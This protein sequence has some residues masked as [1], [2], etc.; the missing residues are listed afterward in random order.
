MIAILSTIGIIVLAVVGV[1][2]GMVVVTAV[3]WGLCIV[4]SWADD[5]CEEM[6]ESDLNVKAVLVYTEVELG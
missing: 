2:V 1:I 5:E 4:A 3:I 6:S